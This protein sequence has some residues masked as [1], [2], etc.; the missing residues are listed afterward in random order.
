[1]TA[2]GGNVGQG[3]LKSLRSAKRRYRVVGVDME[4]LSSG[5]S[6]ADAAYVVPRTGSAGFEECLGEIVRT[7]G[8]EAIYVCSP[9]EL[10]WF[11]LERVRLE[12]EWNVSV[13]VNPPQVVETG[14]DKLATAGFLARAGFPSLG[15][16]SAGDE[17]GLSRLIEE[18]G[19][20]LLMKPR[21][22]SSSHDVFLAGSLR[23][24][25]AVRNLVKDMVVQQYLPDDGAEFTAATLSGPDGRFR[26]AIVLH[27][28]LLQGTTYRTEL[29][30]D[31]GLYAQVGAMTDALGAIGPCNFQFRICDGLP[32]VFEIN[33][34]WSG[35]SGIRYLYGFN[36]CDLAFGLFRLREP[37]T[38]PELRPAVVLRYWNEVV[39]ADADFESLRRG[40]IRHGREVHAG[41]AGS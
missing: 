34:R 12:A 30:T 8:V 40:G 29:C 13:L 7:E 33:P 25:Q 6:L 24:V 2:I 36:D 1:M 20:P 5:F 38:Q 3:V 26:A 17:A 28:H 39:I 22:G 21:R 11:S 10:R 27:R 14:S 41:R 37:V 32:Y 15:T 18:Q 16:V 4:P 23:E 31:P 19:F 35:T 9:P